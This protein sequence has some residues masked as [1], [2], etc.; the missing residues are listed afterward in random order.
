VTRRLVRGLFIAAMPAVT[1][2]VSNAA[3]L[4]LDFADGTLR[5][6]RAGN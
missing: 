5:R 2:G 3:P 4:S 6:L 1:C